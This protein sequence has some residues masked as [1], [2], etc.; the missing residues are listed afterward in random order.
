MRHKCAEAFSKNSRKISKLAEL[1]NG[2]RIISYEM[3]EN[4]VSTHLFEKDGRIIRVSLDAE[5]AE[6]TLKA[7][8]NQ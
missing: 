7:G 1:I 3:G 8:D 2:A 6:W 4:N 5:T